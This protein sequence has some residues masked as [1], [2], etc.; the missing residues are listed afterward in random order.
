VES[1]VASVW[2]KNYAS[3]RRKGTNHWTRDQSFMRS[4][5]IGKNLARA[6]SN[7]WR[8]TSF[9]VSDRPLMLTNQTYTELIAWRSSWIRRETYIYIYIIYIY[10]YTGCPKK[11]YSGLI[12]NNF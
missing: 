11:K 4:A 5:A 9:R 8:K 1:D 6:N 10:I 2:K 3:W 12:R 7:R